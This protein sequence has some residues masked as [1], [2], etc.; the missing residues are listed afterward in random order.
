M[1]AAAER[2]DHVVVGGGSS[3]SVAAAFRQG[4]V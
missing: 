1:S 3:G 2:F 4:V